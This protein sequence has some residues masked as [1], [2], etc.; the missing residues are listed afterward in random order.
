MASRGPAE[1]TTSPKLCRPRPAEATT[2][3]KL[4]PPDPAEATTSPKLWHRGRGRPLPPRSCGAGRRGVWWWR[5]DGAG[6]AVTVVDL[7]ESPRR[8]S[9]CRRGT[10]VACRPIDHRLKLGIDAGRCSPVRAHAVDP[11]VAPRQDR[12]I[13]PLL[14][15]SCCLLAPR[16]PLLPRSCGIGGLSP[17][18]G[19]R[20]APMD[21][22]PADQA[23]A[24]ARG[25]GCWLI[26][27]HGQQRLPQRPFV[28][29]VHNPART[30]API[31]EETHRALVPGR[32]VRHL[33]PLLFRSCAEL[34]LSPRAWQARS[35]AV[36]REQRSRA[37]RTRVIPKIEFILSGSGGDRGW[38]AVRRRSC[39]RG[40]GPCGRGRP[41]RPRR[42]RR[43]R[44]RGRCAARS[45][46]ARRTR[47]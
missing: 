39:R 21:V 46:P 42:A 25:P 45:A 7:P 30:V 10:G 13:R 8:W 2:S 47:R 19:G 31:T 40:A 35:A 20:D 37:R 41:G 24:N 32:K 44:R 17:R 36:W 11:S 43:S 38:S 6:W 34:G 27:D 22:K 4:W 9:I 23:K 33:R 1:A 12:T 14:P 28:S 16:R 29:K 5:R 3:P 18:T 26:A 15:R